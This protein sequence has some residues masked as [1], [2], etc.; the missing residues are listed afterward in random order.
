[1]WNR[2]NAK[3]KTPF[4]KLTV[5]K[6]EIWNCFLSVWSY[7]LKYQKLICQNY[8]FCWVLPNLRKKL[9]N[10]IYFLDIRKKLD[11]FRLTFFLHTPRLTIYLWF[12]WFFSFM[13]DISYFSC[14]G[15]IAS[16]F[17]HLVRLFFSSILG[18]VALQDIQ[19]RGR[20]G[21]CEELINFIFSHFR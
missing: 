8:N 5:N 6:M 3:C 1:M 17:L 15:K 4:T 21:N 9:S 11:Y 16:W 14:T 13:T 12:F 20:K 2:K 18:P 7:I 10:H 19:K